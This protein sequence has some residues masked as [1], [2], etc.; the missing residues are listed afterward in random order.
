MQK[1]RAMWGV[2]QNE[3]VLF[4][5]MPQGLKSVRTTIFERAKCSAGYQADRK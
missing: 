4:D 2:A 1:E 5:A 3:T